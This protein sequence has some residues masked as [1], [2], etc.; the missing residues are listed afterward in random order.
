MK[1]PRQSLYK[2]ANFIPDPPVM[3]QSLRLRSA[4]FGQ[5]R[6]IIETAM[7]GAGTIRKNRTLFMG[8]SANR[9]DIIKANGPQFIDLLGAIPRYIDPNL[10][11]DMGRPGIKSLGDDSRR[12]GFNNIRLEMPGPPFG[13]LAPAGVA[14]A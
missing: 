1:R 9:D 8:L 2:S 3:T 5:P 6:G 12:I 10:G 7:D 11:H 14:G 4:S 13:H